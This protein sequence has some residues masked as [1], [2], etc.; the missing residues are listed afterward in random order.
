[1][2]TYTVKVDDD[3]NKFWYFDGKRHRTDGPSIEW[4]DGT[5][6]WYFDDKLHRTDE[7]AIE[8]VNG[9]KHWY[10]DGKRHR[11][12]GPAIEH[13]DGTKFWYLDDKYLTE[14]QWKQAVNPKVASCVDTINL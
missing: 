3:G 5:K 1:M 7:P 12:D 14:A 11:A 8:W 2:T 9:S 6:F 10:V 4:A 13:D